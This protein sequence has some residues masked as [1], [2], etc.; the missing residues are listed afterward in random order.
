MSLKA[1]RY[2][3]SSK[4]IK[5]SDIL[6]SHGNIEGRK[7]VLQIL[8]AGY[9][10]ADPYINTYKLVRIKNNKLLIGLDTF[11]LSEVKNIYVIGAGKAVQRMAKAFEDKLGDRLTE[12]HI[13]IKKGDY[14][15]LKKI[16]VTYAGH[17]LPD[18]KSAEGAKRIKEIAEKATK[19]DIVI[20]VGS[21]GATSLSALPPPEVSIEDLAKAY[22]LLYYDRGIPIWELNVI[23]HHLSL[24]GGGRINMYVYP[25]KYIYVLTNELWPEETLSYVD[26]YS[27]FKDAINVVKKYDAWD[28]LPQSVKS[29]FECADPKY[30][31]PRKEELSKVFLRKHVV[32]TA[33]YML[34]GA[35]EQAEKMGIKGIILAQRVSAEARD[36]GR[37]LASIAREVEQ[38]KRPFKVPCAVITGG[39]LL[40]TMGKSVKM[41]V[42][43]GRNQEFVLSS[44]TRIEGSDKITV[45]SV[46]SD[47]SDG[48]TDVSGGMSDGYT[49]QRARELNVDVYRALQDHNSYEAL[50]RL[51]DT[52][53]TGNTGTNVQ[54]LRVIYISA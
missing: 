7:I 51:Q 8:E 25:A 50:S 28:E 19:D 31:L 40:V 37:T 48:P 27:T 22:L 2:V 13:N 29:L 10:A 49:M 18:E 21:G 33:E 36:A 54:D 1:S 17:P 26:P 34:K 3:S 9:R 14:N 15:D 24:L 20:Y 42:K 41:D 45:G 44:A 5:N 43:G 11:D 12:G 52:V 23:R 46:D 6:S 4:L 35:K 16:E 53:Y 30:E 47:G 32:M 38:R 39:E